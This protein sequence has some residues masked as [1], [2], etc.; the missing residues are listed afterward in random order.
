MNTIRSA[1]RQDRESLLRIVRQQQNFNEQE[2]AV[3][4]EV[5]DDALNPA[6]ND[7]TLLVAE[8]KG[9]VDGF[10]VYGAI[11]L[12]DSRYDL[13]WV[14]TD[15]AQGRKGIGTLLLKSME[16]MI[17]AQGPAH[18][19]VDTSSTPGYIPARNFYEKHGY[20]IACVLPNFY[21]DG[22]DRVVYLKEV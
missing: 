4:I 19:Y 1:A 8:T 12:T 15:S 13:Y 2:V 14:A 20:R 17:R 11:P 22:D 6:K 5:I 7:Y 3:A 21:R 9:S 10:I 18:I 16:E